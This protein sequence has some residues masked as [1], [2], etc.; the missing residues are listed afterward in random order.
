MIRNLVNQQLCAVERLRE[1]VLKLRMIKK[2]NSA[3][4]LMKMLWGKFDQI[5]AGRFRMWK[6]QEYIKRMR[7][8]RRALMHMIFYAS[9]NFENGFWKWKLLWIGLEMMPILNT[10]LCRGDLVRLAVFIRPGWNSS[11]CL[12]FCCSLGKMV[13]L[14]GKKLVQ[15]PLS[16]W[17]RLRGMSRLHRLVRREGTRRVLEW[18]LV[19]KGFVGLKKYLKSLQ[20]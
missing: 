17:W 10:R 7:F 9:I 19:L 12:R 13:A 16:F 18:F 6:N 8:M 14:R 1:W 5:V 4:I 2:V 11:R 20:I 3:Y 15:Y